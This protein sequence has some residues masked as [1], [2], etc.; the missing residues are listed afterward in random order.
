[1]IQHHWTILCRLS[2]INGQSNNISLIEVVEEIA[3]PQGAVV[4]GGAGMVPASFDLV[5]LW[6]RAVEDHPAVGKV[7]VRFAAAGSDVA[8][9]T[10]EYAIDL[11]HNARTRNII[12]L[13]GF[14]ATLPG[15]YYFHVDYRDCEAECWTEV[16]GLPITVRS[17]AV[18]DGSAKP[19]VG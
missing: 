14:P 3:I 16:G 12:N 4:A 18:E 19:K 2:L 15:R 8:L 7:R 6:G 1:M 11:T 5:T 9:L 10:H 13:V 17:F